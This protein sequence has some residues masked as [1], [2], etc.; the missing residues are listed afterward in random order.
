MKQVTV[1]DKKYRIEKAPKNPWEW[2]VSI[3]KR[4]FGSVIVLYDTS[5]A[6]VVAAVLQMHYDAPE[7]ECRDVAYAA[8]KALKK[9]YEKTSSADLSYY[10]KKFHAARVFDSIH[11]I[12]RAVYNALPKSVRTRAEDVALFIALLLIRNR[13]ILEEM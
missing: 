9:P 10:L 12:R 3:A 5:P 1:Y 2:L 13:E 4:P 7:H 11:A 6:C 8:L